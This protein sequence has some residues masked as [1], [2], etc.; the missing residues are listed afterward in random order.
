LPFLHAAMLFCLL[1]RGG[2][3]PDVTKTNSQDIPLL[4]FV[5]HVSF[6]LVIVVVVKESSELQKKSKQ[7]YS[8]LF[9]NFHTEFL[10]E[11]QELLM[12]RIH[13]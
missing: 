10:S 11:Y 4:V 2:A 12:L 6:H 1:P 13:K 7:Q 5:M 8:R 9:S 3:A